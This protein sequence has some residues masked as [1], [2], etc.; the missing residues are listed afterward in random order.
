MLAVLSVVAFEAAFLPRAP[1]WSASRLQ[2]SGTASASAAAPPPCSG[3]SV[4][5]AAF[6]TL[7]R[8]AWPRL[9]RSSQLRA[10]ADD[11][12]EDAK[13]ETPQAS[14]SWRQEDPAET[15]VPSVSLTRSRDG[16][17]GTATFTFDQPSVLSV[18]DVWDRGLITGLWLRDEEGELVS[19]D[20]ECVF[21]YGKPKQLVAIMV[22]K[23]RAEWE[24]FMRFMERYAETNELSFAS[25]AQS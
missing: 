16:S 20:L 2:P 15:V 22:L 8:H 5:E 9:Q 24:R 12:A 17:T 19:S 21:E 18:N 23:N 1:A 14:V 10:S 6:Q 13:D 7:G 25:A 3:S 11:D 4:S